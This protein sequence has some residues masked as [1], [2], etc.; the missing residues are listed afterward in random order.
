M[1]TIDQIIGSAKDL[2]ACPRL[3]N[4]MAIKDLTLLAYSPQGREFC[5]KH[6]F[7]SSNLLKD[8]DCRELTRYNFYRDE[9]DMG[10]SVTRNA[11]FINSRLTADVKNNAV[12]HHII[13]LD[14]SDIRLYLDD[15]VVADINIS[16]TSRVEI[17]LNNTAKLF[18]HGKGEVIEYYI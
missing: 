16:E 5:I 7:P 13:V 6:D 12:L 2:G 14:N 1:N 11:C 18:C 15:Y 4:G 3:E 8:I 9:I 17:F 10:R